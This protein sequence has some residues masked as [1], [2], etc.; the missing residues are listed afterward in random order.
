MMLEGSY[1]EEGCE[2]LEGRFQ[3]IKRLGTGS[4]GEIYKVLKKDNGAIY[5]AKIERAVK[6]TKHVMLFWESKLMQKLKGKTI[7]P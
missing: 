7:V 4:F 3:V 2:I 5:A 6:N 1:L